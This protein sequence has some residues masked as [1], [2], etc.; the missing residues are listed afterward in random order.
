MILLHYKKCIY[1]C[2]SVCSLNLSH[3]LY[4]C[5]HI[6]K[7]FIC[8]FLHFFHCLQCFDLNPLLFKII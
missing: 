5:V 8:G 2:V 3:T 1:V 4:M 7:I 6:N